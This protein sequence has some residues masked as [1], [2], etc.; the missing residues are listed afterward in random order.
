MW[1]N[2]TTVQNGSSK[3]SLN[4]EGIRDSIDT[5][6]WPEG[7]LPGDVSLMGADTGAWKY[8]DDIERKMKTF[9]VCK[10]H[11]KES[12]AYVYA[13]EPTHRALEVLFKMINEKV[14]HTR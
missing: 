11:D 5:E 9:K 14:R 4:L 7:I 1:S 10:L 3:T 2:C 13:A 6:S 8:D 12:F